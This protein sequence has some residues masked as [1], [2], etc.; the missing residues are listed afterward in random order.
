M[1]L[2]RFSAGNVIFNLETRGLVKR[3]IKCCSCMEHGFVTM[4]VGFQVRRCDDCCG[5]GRTIYDGD[6][7][8]EERRDDLRFAKE[9]VQ[10]NYLWQKERAIERANEK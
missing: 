9:Q 8:K 10:E 2:K 4:G 7:A 1:C 5:T 6:F 3:T